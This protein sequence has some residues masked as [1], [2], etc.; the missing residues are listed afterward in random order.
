MLL[1]IP[2]AGQAVSVALTPT[3]VHLALLSFNAVLGFRLQARP[4]PGCP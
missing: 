4:T 1:C 2:L 3:S